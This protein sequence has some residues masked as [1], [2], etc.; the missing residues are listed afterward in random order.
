MQPSHVSLWL[1][2][3]TDA[4]GV[5]VV[6]YSLRRL[7]GAQGPPGNLGQAIKGPLDPSTMV[8]TGSA[9]VTPP[10]SQPLVGTDGSQQPP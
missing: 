4:K 8:Q 3:D 9:D 2:R 1:R 7:S 5:K 6:I 10:S